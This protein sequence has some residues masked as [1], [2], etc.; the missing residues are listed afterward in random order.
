M[1][2]FIFVIFI[3]VKS[4]ISL[5]DIPDKNIQ[6]INFDIGDG[7][8]QSTVLTSYQDSHGF[9]WFGT[10]DG[11]NLFNGYDFK[12]F[13]NQPGDSLSI[14]DNY[15]ND[16]SGDNYG[17]LWIAS[18]EGLSL[19]NYDL[20]Y[21]KNYQLNQEGTAPE[22][23][24]VHINDQNRIWV[25]TKDGIFTFEQDSGRFYKESHPIVKAVAE[26]YVTVIF[27]DSRKNI[28][29]GTTN[30]LFLY[31]VSEQMV[32]DYLPE[33]EPYAISH[34]RVE[35]ITEDNEGN[36]WV[37]TYGGGVNKYDR[38]Y[39]MKSHLHSD[40]NENKRLSSN[41]VRALVFDNQNNLWIGTFDGLTIYNPIDEKSI[42]ITHDF[43][44]K[45]GLNHGSI[46][47][48]SVDQKG[49]VWIGTYMGGI[50]Y[51]DQD[52]QRFSH[53]YHVPNQKGS[54][55]HNVVSDFARDGKGNYY[56]GTERGGLNYF[57]V[58]RN[59]FRQFRK[60]KNHTI[61][62]LLLDENGF[63]WVGTFK[64]GLQ[65]FN[66]KYSELSQPFINSNYPFMGRAS[67]NDIEQ[68]QRGFL[69]LATNKNGGVFKFD[70]KSL[71]FIDFAMQDSL[72]SMLENTRVMSIM[73]DYQGN[74]WLATHGKGII[75]F[76]E[77]EKKI[78]QYQTKMASLSINSNDINHIFSDSKNRI[79]VAT[80][81]AGIILF[82]RQKEIFNAFT[83]KDGL[84]NNF[85]IGIME[86]DEG[87]LWVSCI[88]GISKFD[89]EAITFR[90][91]N[92]ASGLP[93]QEINEGAFLKDNDNILLGGSNGFIKFN[94]D[95]MQNNQFI[96]PV[97]ITNFKLFN[98]PIVPGGNQKI[99]QKHMLNTRE[100][101]LEHNQ[102]IFTIEFAAL[103]YLK[104]EQNHYMYR[105]DG[106]EN[107]WN[108]VGNI[109]SANYTNLKEGKYTF[110]VK[111]AN[112]D[113]LWNH[114]PTTL[115]IVVK[116]PLWKSW[117]AI[118]FYICIIMTG[119]FIIRHISHKSAQMKGEI[120]FRQLEK[121]KLAEVHKLKLQS[122]TDVSHE[123]RT[124]LTLI[125][126]PLQQ[127]MERFK[128]DNQVKK[129]LDIMH[130]NT[131]RLLLL[132]NQ[133]LEISELEFG[134]TNTI[135][136]PTH[137]T[138]ML[139]S[140]VDNFQGLAKKHYL[141]LQFEHNNVP[142]L[143]FDIDRDK[144]E[145]I[146][147]NLISNAIK[148][149]KPYG[150]ILVTLAFLEKKEQ[151]YSFSL[152]IED[153]GIGIKN[154]L[155]HR[156]FE[157]FYKSK[158]MTGTGVGLSL[159][160]SLVEVMGGRINLISNPEE[161]TTFIVN[162]SFTMSQN[163]NKQANQIFS[164]TLPE[165]YSVNVSINDS[166]LDETQK[167]QNEIN[168]KTKILLVEDDD[169]LKTY[170]RDNLIEKF[171]IITAKNGLKGLEKVEQE[172]PDL[173]ISDVMMPKMDGITFCQ[174]IKTNP[175]LCH[176][177]VI[178]LTAKT[179]D[180]ERLNGLESGADD[181]LTKPFILRELLVRINN[182][183]Q[184]R[185]NLKK[186]Y[187]ETLEINN[188]EI[189]L[190]SYDDVL[191]KKINRIIKENVDSSNLNVDFLGEQVGLSRVHLYRKLKALTGKSP[192]D[193][194][195]NVR[196]KIAAQM[197]QQNKVN[198]T[199]VAFRAGFQDQHYFGKVF[200]KQFG[201]SP[202]DYA[203]HSKENT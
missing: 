200:K 1:R 38:S 183:L 58:E 71:K 99:L 180:S 168:G 72:H 20:S 163:Q 78:L 55:S 10:R 89:P 90:N 86:D 12:I 167:K 16:I 95:N 148:F 88:N 83:T 137:L 132:I 69:W 152:K 100:I 29:V 107:D 123:F 39:Q 50:N 21:F 68:D 122:F 19:F 175:K 70:K 169:D 66:V 134:V 128:G 3:I 2:V 130:T 62:S 193:L 36:V 116:P 28:W 103:S 202:S 45:D 57:D 43:M 138:K 131:R 7:L 144:L 48:L 198:I 127:I 54:L 13:R 124:P 174:K 160:K 166:A 51:Y 170:L 189:Q 192:S 196:M 154:E 112:N 178:L 102:S 110:M 4:S 27:V 6:L 67:I 194:I 93:L 142:D 60:T 157:R 25:G 23:S 74:L 125:I 9:F 104:P 98:Q 173:I 79:W 190:N 199:D 11:L 140:I 97:K 188:P 42:R 53:Y 151:T 155:K 44:K 186:I 81:G 63:L 141:N 114:Q 14:I 5:A 147:Y 184:S 117:W 139:Q 176:I 34:K 91:Y 49:S 46:R 177:P 156:V 24:T 40:D 35:D 120:K 182:L 129:Q 201:M 161:G 76:N 30:G 85:A 150:Y 22:I 75:V 61:K 165:E 118:V 82:D 73:Q 126:D 84:Q 77:A 203:N 172:N 115:S 185:Q 159:T 59:V 149:N 65:R 32:I 18:N 135:T 96:P 181:Y 113:Q 105:L 197:L 158:N 153:S 195:K 26:N 191:L 52:N 37:G 187:R 94:P 92:F 106:L 146:T 31:D 101:V 162:L 80:N 17:N 56:I 109:R 8:S 121:E 119:L 108:E 64:N 145:K 47:S 33:K 111:A 87:N 143:M 15:I 171:E 179:K 41:F 133:I 164:K 136:E